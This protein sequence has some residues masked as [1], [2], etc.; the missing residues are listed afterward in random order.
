MWA[1]WPASAATAMV[2]TANVRI[3]EAAEA[4]AGIRSGD[5][6]YL[7]CAAADALGP[8]WMRWSRA[9]RSSGTWGS[10]T[11]TARVPARI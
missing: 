5:Q 2:Q 4:V 8:A 9:R 3:V 7:H 11:S 10:S 1:E 6:V